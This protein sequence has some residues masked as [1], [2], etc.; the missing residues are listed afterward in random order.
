MKPVV[1]VIGA[2]GKMG[3]RCSRKLLQNG[4]FFN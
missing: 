3:I 1:S 4:E 2:G